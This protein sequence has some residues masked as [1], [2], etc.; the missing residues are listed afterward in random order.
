M[1]KTTLSIILSIL[2]GVLLY[3][4]SI[5]NYNLYHIMIEIAISMIGILIFSVSLNART[6]NKVNLLVMLGPGFFVASL[7]TML[8]SFTYYG[9]NIIP[10]YDAN[11]PT[12]L[13][14]I[15]SYILA[16]SFLITILLRENFPHYFG[17]LI[18]YSI[19]G[20]I[21]IALSFLKI[22]PDC[23][24]PEVGLTFFKKIS[25]YIIILIYLVSILLL[26]RAKEIDKV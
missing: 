18:S 9:M 11:L 20:L 4:V 21:F 23:F 2:I 12:Q 6:F 16:F 24:T 15:L 3:W 25:E 7:I 22:F 19:L 26:S 10:G 8:H 1:K 14:I 5:Y 17:A 13:W